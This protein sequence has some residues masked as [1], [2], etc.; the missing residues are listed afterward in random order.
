MHVFVSHSRE[1]SSAAFRLCEEL[2]KRNI[3]TWLDVRDL[4]PGLE[5]NR[6][7][8]EA[9]R[10]AAGFVFLIGPAGA[11]DRYQSFEWQQV[12][13]DEFYLDPSKPLIPVLIGDPEI[14]GFLKTRHTL[15]LK[16]TRDSLE[17]VA[18][19]VLKAI[20]DPSA[21]VDETKLKLGHEV[22]LQ[23]LESLREYSKA[24]GEEDLKRAA[25]RISD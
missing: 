3:K 15:H 18:D 11:T 6:S 16:D 13:E 23:A 19:L 24:I 5:W 20:A 7:V 9:I 10:S 21:S 2:G 1:N 25:T 8:M 4:E 12:I 17:G 14:P 22:R